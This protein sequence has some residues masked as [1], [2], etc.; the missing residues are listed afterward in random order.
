M[1]QCNAEYL[2]EFVGALGTY[3]DVSDML[4]ENLEDYAT[5]CEGVTLEELQEKRSADREEAEGI[6]SEMS[7]NNRVRANSG[8]EFRSND[9]F[10]LKQVASCTANHQ[11]PLG[12]EPGEKLSHVACNL[13]A[14]SQQ[15]RSIMILVLSNQ[16]PS[17]IGSSLI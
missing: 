15:Q 16:R 10:S 11:Q 9:L 4:G 12:Q 13:Q 2:Q 17:C 7:A 14:S 3:G 6:A 5:F 8:L 1:C